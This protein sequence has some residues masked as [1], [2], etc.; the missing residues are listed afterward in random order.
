VPGFEVIVL[1]LAIAVAVV[2]VVKR[3]FKARRST[4]TIK[5]SFRSFIEK[6]GDTEK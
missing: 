6:K 5:F 1:G 3:H 2:V 4:E